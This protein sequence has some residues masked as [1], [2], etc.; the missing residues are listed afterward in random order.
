MGAREL[1][2][3]VAGLLRHRELLG[4]PRP[5]AAADP[6]RRAGDQP[7]LPRA[8]P[9]RAPAAAPRVR[10]VV[11][12]GRR[13]GRRR[14]RARD[15]ARGARRCARSRQRVRRVR[16][17]RPRRRRAGSRRRRR[18]SRRRCRRAARR[19]SRTR[20][21]AS[22]GSGARRRPTRQA[23]F[24]VFGSLH[25]LV[26]DEPPRS[27]SRRS[28]LL[29]DVARRERRRRAARRR[30]DR[31]RAAHAHGHRLRH[32]RARRRRHALLPGAVI[33]SSAT[34]C[35]PIPAQS[36]WAFAET[37]RFDHPTDILGRCV[38][39]DV[40]VGG[41]APARRSGRAAAVGI[42]QPRRGR[43]PGRRPVRHPPSLRAVA[44][45]RSRAAQV[46]RRAHR[47]PRWA[48]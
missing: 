16:R 43:V 44:R 33:P 27:P 6:A 42:G 24:A 8:R 15:R 38:P 21:G 2:R 30:A 46:H 34:R 28:G 7:D 13:R 32:D 25:A 45:V 36:A 5:D 3:G 26:A 48:R 10:A 19:R 12:A 4:A 47:D 40:E 37:L 11:H 1:R 17:L 20:S 22:P 14:D 31:G 29:A 9:A 41:Q 35:S 18:G 23:M 39:R